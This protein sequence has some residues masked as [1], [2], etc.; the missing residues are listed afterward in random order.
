MIEFKLKN[1]I[2]N[3]YLPNNAGK[4]LPL[5]ILNTYN[6]EGKEV[7]EKCLKLN[8]PNFVLA[9]ISNLDW[10]NEM[11]PWKAPNL[12]KNEPD[13]KG[14]A[15][16]YL[17]ELIKDIIP[18][19]K[20]NLKDLKITDYIL[21]GYS[22]AGLFAIYS[23]YKT[24]LFSKLVLASGSLWYPGFLDFVKTNNISKNIKQIYFSL[25]NKESKTRNEKVKVV[26]AN[27]KEI[28]KLFQNQNI[29]T[30]YEENEGNHF[31]DATLRM[32]K[33]I[34]WILEKE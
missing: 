6:N 24:D 33:G 17:E 8:C 15:D 9:T 23:A 13:F 7:Y 4:P 10:D 29:K 12:G 30:I 26:E 28:Q 31:K 16:I 18:K 5:V 27:T 19:I 34:K 11:T 14:Q 20:E 25:G 22:L 1:K 21:A 32:A 2:I 3:V